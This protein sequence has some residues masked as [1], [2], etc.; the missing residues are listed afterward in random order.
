MVLLLLPRGRARMRMLYRNFL[1]ASTLFCLSY[2]L[3][4][5]L[6]SF[7]ISLPLF[8]SW[9]RL[10]TCPLFLFYCL[11]SF[12]PTLTHFT[13]ALLHPLL[14]FTYPTRSSPMSSLFFFG[15]IYDSTTDGNGTVR[16]AFGSIWDLGSEASAVRRLLN[17]I[18]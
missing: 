7:S 10:S 2:I 11:L 15:L 3:L 18:G 16:M 4:S 8:Q 5:F 6:R 13:L 1:E 14:H 17:V 12:T 9:S